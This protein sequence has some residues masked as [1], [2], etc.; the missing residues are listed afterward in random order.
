MTIRSELN[1]PPIDEELVARLA[2][3]AAKID[4]ARTGEWENALEEFNRLSPRP[5]AF[6]DFQGIYGAE[7]HDVYVRRFL[8][9]HNPPTIPNLSRD[10]P[11][12]SFARILNPDCP[13]HEQWFLIDTLTQNL[14]DS[15]ISDL[16]YWPGEYFGDG[17]NAREMTATEM[18]D[19]ALARQAERSR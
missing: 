18:A 7:D 8:A 4:G 19:A 5:L 10:D 1:V 13:D 12:S 14:A 3:L 2:P 11:A 16:V 15:Q 9:T 17:D 6:N